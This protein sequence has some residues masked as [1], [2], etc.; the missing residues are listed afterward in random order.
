MLYRC[1]AQR[2][3]TGKIL[4]RLA[5][6]ARIVETFVKEQRRRA[7][8]FKHALARYRIAVGFTVVGYL[9]A[10][11]RRKEFDRGNIIEIFYHRQPHSQSSRILGFGYAEKR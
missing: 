11:P 4:K 1:A 6:V 9:N 10:R 3:L 8:H 5:A 2:A 7:V